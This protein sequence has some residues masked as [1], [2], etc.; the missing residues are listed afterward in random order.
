MI[1]SRDQM[2]H[3]IQLNA[4]P[5]RIIS[6]VPSITE[7]L[8]DLGLTDEVVGITD[9]CLYSEDQADEKTRVGGP[10]N[11]DIARI[12]ELNPDLVIGSKEE[13]DSARIHELQ[14]RYPVWLCDVS[15]MADALEMIDS[16]GRLVNCQSNADH[17]R[18][19]LA[20]CF[21]KLPDF[22]PI[23]AAYLIWKD[24]YMAAGGDTFIN[25][26]LEMIGLVNIMAAKRRY[27]VISITDLTPADVILL[28]S[29][30]YPFAPADVE[31]FQTRFSKQQ[32]CLVDGT[33]F[34]WYGSR[35]RRAPAYWVDLRANRIRSS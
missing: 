26:C 15:T 6:L 35:L 14:Q 16:L 34:S 18:A 10:K 8:F 25:S 3:Q 20:D 2:G 28:S 5:R 1:G 21:R 19:D 7:L 31:F 13:N 23:R 30:P 11:F 33:M 32:I 29:E 27:P 4:Y 22:P 17:L 24:P 9:Y 12:H